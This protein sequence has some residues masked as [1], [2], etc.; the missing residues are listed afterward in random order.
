MIYPGY[1]PWDPYRPSIIR[2]P[3]DEIA[4]LER[5]L[6]DLEDEKIEIERA[7]EDV[8][9][10]ISRRKKDSTHTSDTIN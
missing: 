10:E 7:I 2:R 5:E 8:K 6:E 1:N 4:S 3:E 9:K